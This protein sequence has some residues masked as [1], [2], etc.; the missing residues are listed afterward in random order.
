MEGGNHREAVRPATMSL[1]VTQKRDIVCVYQAS[2]GLAQCSI[3]LLCDRPQ[4]HG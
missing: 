4:E 3:E 1:T 2:I